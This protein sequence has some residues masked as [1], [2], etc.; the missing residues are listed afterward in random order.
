M[1][2]AE[3]GALTNRLK[4][5]QSLYSKPYPSVKN[6]LSGSITARQVLNFVDVSD[7]KNMHL[8]SPA[9]SMQYATSSVVTTP[10]V[11][12]SRFMNNHRDV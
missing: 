4:K 9:P 7:D 5:S 8:P 1:E 2:I 12:S 10:V 3:S 11:S 6:D